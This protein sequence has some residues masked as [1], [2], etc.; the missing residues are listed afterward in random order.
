MD[1]LI[2]VDM[3]EHMLRGDAKHELSRVVD[4][5]NR[6][7]ARVRGRGGRVVFIQHDG[8]PGEEF[9]P[10]TPAWEILSSLEIESDDLRVRKKLNSIP[11]PSTGGNGS[12]QATTTLP[13]RASINASAQG[14]VRPWWAQGSRVT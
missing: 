13:T 9:D 11:R 14:R 12:R 8:A 10:F 4:R 5:I 3:Q 7:A 2:V 6:L 1:V